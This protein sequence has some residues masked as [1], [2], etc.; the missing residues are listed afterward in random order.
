MAVVKEVFANVPSCVATS[1]SG[2]TTTDTAW[3]M[4]TGST[5]FPVAATSTTPQ[6]TFY[7][8]DPADT[9]HEI[10][11]VTVTSGTSWTVVRG[12]LGTAGVSHATGATWVQVISHGTLQNF[13]QTPSAATSAVS[14][15][16]TTTETLIALYQ[17]TADEIIA[18]ATWEIVTFGPIL[19][20]ATPTQLTLTL[21]WGWVSSGTPGTSL[22]TCVTGTNGVAIPL[23][24]AA[25]SSFDI[26]GS[27]TLVDTT[28]VVSNLNFWANK[29]TT[30]INDVASS[31]ASTVISGSGPLALTAKYSLTT[32]GNSINNLAPLIY[33]AA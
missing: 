14:V 5:S 17:P 4:G 11:Q 21:R 18:G 25:G 30:F 15:S 6:T 3:T 1:S 9:T 31:Q 33:R 8:T 20:S 23:S 16:A 28:H 2:T 7:V 24:M 29:T 27:V 12:A 13:K 10:V 32:A 19:S 22:L 26:N